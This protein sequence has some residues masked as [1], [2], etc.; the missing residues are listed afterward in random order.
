LS[1]GKTNGSK[2]LLWTDWRSHVWG[3]AA[4]TS[5][6]CWSN[7]NCLWGKDMIFL[8]IW[9]CSPSILIFAN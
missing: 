2:S 7:P 1:S 3:W 5:H 6:S 8:G 9:W 4:V